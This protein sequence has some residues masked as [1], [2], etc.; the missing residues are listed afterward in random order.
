MVFPPHSETPSRVFEVPGSA[1]SIQFDTRGNL[2]LGFIH[3]IYFVREYSV[4]SGQSVRLIELEDGNAS[5][6]IAIDDQNVLY[7]NTKSFIGGD[8]KLFRPE[9]RDKPYIEIKDPLRPLKV[10]VAGNALYVG[11]Y[12]T[13]TDALARYR[14]RSTDQT[15]L[16]SIPNFSPVALAVNPDGSLV[17]TTVRSNGK[18]TVRVYQTKSPFGS[19]DIHQGDT[20]AMVAD[21]SGNLYIA[22][23][24]SRILQC[25]FSGGCSHSFETNL[26]IRDLAISPL[27][28]MLYVLASHVIDGKPG[29]QAGV[30]IYN[31]K[32]TS[33]VGYIPTTGYNPNRVVIEP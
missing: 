18:L 11:Y 24:K 14:L 17:A 6:S 8:I 30:Y 7:V 20:Q 33:R 21:D 16:T 10:Y 29:F 32:N 19:K 12:G 27:D 2:Y 5:S 13:F 9:D 22:Q 23:R 3:D 15:W 25:T 4:E 26:E 31:P 1:N 28:G